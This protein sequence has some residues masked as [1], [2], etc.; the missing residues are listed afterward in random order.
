MRA[1]VREAAHEV[2]RLTGDLDPLVERQLDALAGLG[3]GIASGVAAERRADAADAAAREVRAQQSRAVRD[4]Y[5][6]GGPV[7]LWSSLLGAGTPRDLVD[8]RDATRR[9]LAALEGAAERAA[10]ERDGAATAAADARTAT[11]TAASTVADV[12]DAA[13]ALDARITAARERLD[14]LSAQARATAEAEHTARVLAAAAADAARRR[15][16]AARAAV[17]ATRADDVPTDWDALYRQAAAE[18]C[19]GM[20]WTLLAAVGQVESRHGRDTGPSTAGA[21]GP[22]QFMPATF[23]AVG[24]DGDRDGA[25][26]PW[27]PADAV[28]SAA[29]YLCQGGAGQGTAAGTRRALLRYNHAE[30]YADLVLGVEA[31]LVARQ[32]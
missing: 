4:L 28:H 19:P 2:E 3:A 6:D 13:A 32:P 31:D 11:T 8:R 15:D 27:R 12:A 30:W 16:A 1:E 14:R 26:D 25:T 7:A 9:L 18:R 17:V 20:P 29:V 22:M 10:A 24:V 23:A 5:V 21:V